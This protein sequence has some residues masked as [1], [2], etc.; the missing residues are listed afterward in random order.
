MRECF[1]KTSRAAVLLTVLLVGV[2]PAPAWNAH[3][4]RT[5]TYLALDG[6]PPDAPAFLRDPLVR[7][8]I[9]FQSNEPDRQRGWPSHT[10]GHINEPEHY[11]D[12]EQL[13]PFGLTLDT[14]PPFRGEYLRALAIAKHTHPEIV[15]PYHPALD[16]N[17]TKEWPGY[18]PYAIVEH[19]TALQSAFHQVRILERLNDPQRGFQLAQ[20]RENAIYHMGKL[21]H[22][23]ADAAQPLHTTIH[24]HGWV[25]PNPNGYTTD[26]GF[27]RHIDGEVL[28]QHKLTYAALRPL[29]KYEHSVTPEDP[30]NDALAHIRRSFAQ[31]EPLYRL[32]K[33]G[34]LGQ[35]EG[36]AFIEARLTDAAGML[37]ALYASAWSSAAPSDEQVEKYVYYDDMQRNPLPGSAAV[38]QPSTAKPAATP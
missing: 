26:K 32:Q 24:H 15:E 13:E 31:V 5:I 23:V 18:L 27:H 28:E 10:L 7:D 37:A 34:A 36:K 33:T 38:S 4:H 8:R 17:R 20:A 2:V 25:G 11:I 30:W 14:L 12:I 35:A 9:A 6:L 1:V 19:Y 22:F 3:G 16:L 21:S 29:M